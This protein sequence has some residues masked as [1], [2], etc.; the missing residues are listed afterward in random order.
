MENQTFNYNGTDITF[1]SSESNVMVNATEMASQFGKRPIDWLQNSQ[2]QSFIDE[3]AKVRKSTLA[4][5]V[6]VTKG[7]NSSGTWMHE[8]V[9]LEFARWLSPAFAIWCNDRIKE[10]LTKGITALPQTI[11][12][13]L[14]NPDLLINALTQ[15]KAE[16]AAKAELKERL[17]DAEEWYTIK[18]WAKFR[19]KNWRRYNWRALKALSFEHGREVKKAFDANYGEVN[20]YHRSIFEIYEK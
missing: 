13:M 20:L 18:R 3:L 9:A 8:D 17:D 14:A 2:T 15:L 4:D 6:R 19:G 12:E 10:L 16:R 11:D 1:L 7:G 5:L